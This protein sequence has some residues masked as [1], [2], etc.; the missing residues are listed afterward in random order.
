[1]EPFDALVEDYKFYA[2]V[3]YGSRLVSYVILADLIRS[4]WR[5]KTTGA[6]RPRAIDQSDEAGDE[7]A[8]SSETRTE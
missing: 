4:G 5:P 1:L 2:S 7:K 8:A 3:H 6:R